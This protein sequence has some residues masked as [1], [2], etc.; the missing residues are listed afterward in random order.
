MAWIISADKFDIYTDG[1]SR[2]NSSKPDDPAAW[3]FIVVKNGE[4]IG[5]KSD[6]LFGRTNNQM[7]LKAILEALKWSNKLGVLVTIY[8]DSQLCIDSITKWMFGWAD[9]GWKKADGSPVKNQ[10]LLREIYELYS[11]T[12]HK[13]E[14]VKG[15]SGDR[16]N[17]MVDE[18]VNLKMDEL[19]L[20]SEYSP[21]NFH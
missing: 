9:K 13:F 10:D 19:I 21:L 17:E 15:H 2:G 1:G 18:L 5:S 4:K 8:T 11:P 3:A 7:E 14:K 12:K 16:F 20:N 6:A